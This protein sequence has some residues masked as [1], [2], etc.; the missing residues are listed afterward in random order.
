[1]RLLIVMLA[2][3]GLVVSDD[4]IRKVMCLS[5]IES[6]IILAFL[7]TGYAVGREA[8]IL[9]AADILPVDPTPQ[10]LMLTAIVIGVCF[11]SL[12]LAFIVKVHQQFGTLRP[13]QLHD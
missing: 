2:A 4:L 13:S 12:A 1:M 3:Y 11:N 9:D 7:N 6:M 8:P 10:A 5:I